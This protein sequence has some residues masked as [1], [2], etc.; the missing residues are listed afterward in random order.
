[1][2]EDEIAREVG[3][4]GSQYGAEGR[5]VYKRIRGELTEWALERSSVSAAENEAHRLNGLNAIATYRR[6]TEGK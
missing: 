1:M 4:A 5:A 3:K 2:T 6:L